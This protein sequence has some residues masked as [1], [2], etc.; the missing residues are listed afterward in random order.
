MES[1]GFVAMTTVY[2]TTTDGREIEFSASSAI[3][4]I[5][6]PLHQAAGRPED[7]THGD[8]SLIRHHVWHGREPRATTTAA[9]TWARAFND[10][11]VDARSRRRDSIQRR[12]QRRRPLFRS[13][14]M[15]RSEI[16]SAAPTL[17]LYRTYII[18]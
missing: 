13:R 6:F 11:M 9:S 14:L 15:I 16:L 4:Y 5:F 3:F 12:I 18:R 10:S 8:G 17:V 1:S 7:G 2:D